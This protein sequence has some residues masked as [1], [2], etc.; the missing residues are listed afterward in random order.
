MERTWLSSQP[1]HLR[2]DEQLSS[3]LS[4]GECRRHTQIFLLPRAR[5]EEGPYRAQP[6]TTVGL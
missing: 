6:P 4:H 1:K 2:I 5:V 3:L